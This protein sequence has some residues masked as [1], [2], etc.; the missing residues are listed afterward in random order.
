MGVIF[1]NENSNT[2]LK[3][4][5]VLLCK[6]MSGYVE[7]LLHYLIHAEHH[8]LDEF[9]VE[10]RTPVRLWWVQSDFVKRFGMMPSGHSVFA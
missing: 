10:R 1:F 7:N 9:D 4:C 6:L 2:G 3:S 8:A 5:F